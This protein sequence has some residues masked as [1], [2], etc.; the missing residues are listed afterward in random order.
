MPV[1]EHIHLCPQF[2]WSHCCGRSVGC[3]SSRAA[4]ENCDLTLNPADLDMSVVLLT[5]ALLPVHPD[6]L[7]WPF[8]S[9]PLP[10]VPVK[11]PRL[12]SSTSVYRGDCAF[13]LSCK[14]PGRSSARQAWSPASAVNTLRVGC[15]MTAV[16]SVW[17]WQ[18]GKC[19]AC[20]VDAEGR[21]GNSPVLSASI[22]R[23]AEIVSSQSDGLTAVESVISNVGG[24]WFSDATKVATPVFLWM[25]D[26]CD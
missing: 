23:S 1:K 3:V 26:H 14:R 7:R 10:A 15:R 20:K 5:L 17:V 6:G 25:D 18:G 4:V 2:K 13:L 9:P 19:L 11:M 8:F 24:N 22:L 21:T 16:K 12:V